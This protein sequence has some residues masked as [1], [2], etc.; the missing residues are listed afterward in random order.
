MIKRLSPFMGKI[1]VCAALLSVCASIAFG[2]TAAKLERERMTGIMAPGADIEQFRQEYLNY[3]GE[4]QDDMRL[5]SAVPVIQRKFSSVGLKPVAMLEQAKAAITSMPAEE[6]V[7][8]RAAYSKVPGWRQMP[9]ALI[10]P[11]LRKQLQANLEAQRSGQASILMVTPDNCSDPAN[12]TVT[13]TDISVSTAFV[14]AGEIVMESLP[15]DALTFEG[16]AAA[17]VLL[18]GLKA[19]T[20]ALQTLKDIREDCKT[21]DFQA[22]ITTKLTAVPGLIT[23]STTTTATNISASTSTT[24]T[25]ISTSTSTTATNITT[26]KTAIINND[27]TNTTTILT[28]IDTAKNLIVADAHAN[29]DEMKNLLLRTQIEADL[30][31]TDGAAFVALYETPT[32]VC[33]VSLNDAGLSQYATLPGVPAVP[34][35]QC[36]LLDLVRAIVRD[37]IANIG[38]GTN[39]QSFFN[40]AETQKAQGKYKLAY[41]SYRQ[42][43]KAASSASTK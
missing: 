14:I 23:A 13:N 19:A 41:A 9:D 25:N 43:F 35:M 5:F 39:A 28:A 7:R 30:S 10:R 11:E 27:N 36:G 4:F 21:D 12:A 34:I 37:T 32:N 18:G 1:F 38:A 22:D 26:A 31:S 24:A 2:Q 15:T 40:V 20:L 8:M 3:L 6:L 42:A 17:S 16:H 29:K 33:K